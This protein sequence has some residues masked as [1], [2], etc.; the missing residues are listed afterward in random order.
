[1]WSVYLHSPR[2][3]LISVVWVWIEH[4]CKSRSNRWYLAIW[5]FCLPSLSRPCLY[6]TQCWTGKPKDI[7][8][9]YEKDI[10]LKWHCHYQ[11]CISPPPPHPRI[12]HLLISNSWPRMASFKRYSSKNSL[13]CKKKHKPLSGFFSLQIMCYKTLICKHENL[14]KC[15]HNYL[16]K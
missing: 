1:M 13:L 8:T 11:W 15:D 5:T 10:E 4:R 16:S 7:G 3:T 14:F 9:L 2:W 6:W 12:V